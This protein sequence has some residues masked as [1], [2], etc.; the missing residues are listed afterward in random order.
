MTDRYTALWRRS[1]EEERRTRRSRRRQAQAGCLALEL[2]GWMAGGDMYLDCMYLDLAAGEW[3]A[4]GWPLSC[5]LGCWAAGLL[6]RVTLPWAQARTYS[7]APTDWPTDWPTD[8]RRARS[9]AG[10][11]HLE[12]G[13]G[14]GAQIIGFIKALLRQP[15][16]LRMKYME[17]M[18]WT[19]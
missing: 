11:W 14:N 4:A 18:A 19:A 10:P 6:T 1:G 5:S 8:R 9:D 12:P 16:T 7:P 13:T 15:R 17:Y 3:V 2:C